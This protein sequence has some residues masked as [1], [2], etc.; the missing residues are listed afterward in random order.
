MPSLSTFSFFGY[1]PLSSLLPPFSQ[2]HVE[3]SLEFFI[4]GSPNSASLLFPQPLVAPVTSFLAAT[5]ARRPLA[6]SLFHDEPGLFFT[7]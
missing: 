2:A 7:T 5:D 3:V 4:P 1:F 6:F